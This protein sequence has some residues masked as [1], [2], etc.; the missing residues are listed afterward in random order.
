M[1]VSNRPRLQSIAV[2]CRW[3]RLRTQRRTCPSIRAHSSSSWSTCARCACSPSCSRSRPLCRRS[4]M[5][6][7]SACPTATLGFQRRARSTRWSA[8]RA[9]WAPRAVTTLSRARPRRPPRRRRCCCPSRQRSS[10]ASAPRPPALRPR[11]P[12]RRATRRTSRS[13]CGPT[14]YATS[15][16]RRSSRTRCASTWAL[17]RASASAFRLTFAHTLICIYLDI[18]ESNC[19]IKI[20]YLVN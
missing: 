4:R 7:T 2:I 3:I 13:S 6:S 19:V 12:R 14:C 16:S 20:I 11:P 10:S 1:P 18:V 5:A 8:R 17:C 9:L 15:A